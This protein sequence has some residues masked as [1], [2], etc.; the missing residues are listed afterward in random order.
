MEF[1]ELIKTRESIRDYDPEKP[2]SKELLMHILE[3]GRLA[4]SAGNRQ[5]WTFV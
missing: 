2:V 3:A 4:P 1:Y 5:P